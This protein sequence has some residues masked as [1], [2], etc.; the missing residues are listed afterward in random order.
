MKKK[1]QNKPAFKPNN[2]SYGLGFDMNPQFYQYQQPMQNMPPPQF[3]QGFGGGFGQPPKMGMLP[4]KIPPPQ[5]HG[6]P[7]NPWYLVIL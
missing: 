4:G 7:K 5:Q 2:M 3:G 1:K 6:F